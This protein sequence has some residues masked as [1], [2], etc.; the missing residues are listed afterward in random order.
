MRPTTV[1]EA[2]SGFLLQSGCEPVM[3]A[4]SQGESTHGVPNTGD[5]QKASH[6]EKTMNETT[7]AVGAV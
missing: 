5:T 4:G 3:G 2:I 7:A 6:M 1:N